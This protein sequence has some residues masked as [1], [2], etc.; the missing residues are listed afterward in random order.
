MRERDSAL[1]LAHAMVDIGTAA[2]R[3][4]AAVVS[5]MSQPLGRAIGNAL[6][7]AEALDTLEGHGPPDFAEFVIELATLVVSLAS[8]A[9]RTDIER[10]LRSG[11]GRDAFRRMVEAQGG[12][13]AAFDDRSRL[14]TAAIQHV[15][16]AESEGYVS[17]LDALTVANA[18]IALGAGRQRK[19]DSIDVSVGVVLQAKVGD[20]IARG[21]PI[22]IIHANAEARLADAERMLR[23]GVTISEAPVSASPL[24]LERLGAS[25]AL[26]G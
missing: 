11:A 25:A 10:A 19:G 26:P 6:E 18:S 16:T 5:D 15:V 17:R 13:V 3:R 24:I 1:A 14:P 9:G 4:M 12:D 21:Q 8:G 22:A 23:S 20:Q 7:V 2:G